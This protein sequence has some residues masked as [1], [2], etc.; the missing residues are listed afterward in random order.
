MPRS[1]GRVS[2]ARGGG[3]GG[4]WAD[5]RHLEDEGGFAARH[6]GLKT[7]LV[8]AAAEDAG[9]AFGLA[10]RNESSTALQ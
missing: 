4:G 10:Q 2:R 8:E 9:A 6:L 7:A 3:S 1:L 5:V